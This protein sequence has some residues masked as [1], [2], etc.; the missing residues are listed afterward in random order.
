M[1]ARSYRTGGSVRIRGGSEK[2]D[3][4]R[5]ILD[6]MARRQP[7]RE[8]EIAPYVSSPIY[9][10]A[11]GH[12]FR[13][14]LCEGKEVRG[15]EWLG[16]NRMYNNGTCHSPSEHWLHCRPLLETKERECTWFELVGAS[17]GGLAISA[18]EEVVEKVATGVQ[19]MAG[20]VGSLLD[21]IWPYLV[22]IMGVAFGG[23]IILAITR[24][25]VKAA[26]RSYQEKTPDR[27]RLL[28]ADKV[29]K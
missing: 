22:I 27:I 17:L 12:T 21:R 1:T 3:C 14:S 9:G 13:K 16:P 18:V 4:A 10:A 6:L 11:E 25:G 2:G 24:G 8:G 23:V 5:R 7:L 15:Y 20:W 19:V 29:I 26:F 28:G